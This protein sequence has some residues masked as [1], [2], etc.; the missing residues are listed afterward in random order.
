[1][2]GEMYSLAES[3]TSVIVRKCCEAIKVLIKP[4]VFQKL[5]KE[6]IEF[7]ASEFKKIIGIP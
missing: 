3:T 6:R 7:I 1:M 5:T 4:L 2:C